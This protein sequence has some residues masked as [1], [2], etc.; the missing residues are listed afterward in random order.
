MHVRKNGKKAKRVLLG[1]QRA[2]FTSLAEMFPRK[3][4][5]E[6]YVKRSHEPLTL[7]NAHDALELHSHTKFAGK[8]SKTQANRLKGQI[9]R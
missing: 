9:V 3:G 4:Q 5:Q 1:K 6:C 7:E 2:N 8:C